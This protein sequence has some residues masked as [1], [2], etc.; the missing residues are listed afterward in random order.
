MKRRGAARLAVLLLL[1][2][3][4]AGGSSAAQEEALPGSAPLRVPFDR[5]RL[6]NGLTVI[7]HEDHRL[8]TVVVNLWFRVGSKDESPGRTG[9]AHLFEHLMFM[10]TRN[11]PNGQYDA[12]MEAA[13]GTNN[14][15]TSE[16]RT[17][18]VET[19][20]SNL[21]ETFLWL[22]ADRLANLADGMT[23]EKV[24]LQREVVKNERRESYENRPY[25]KAD[26][27]ISEQM[28]PENHPYHHPVIGSH[29]DLSA[30]TAED[31]KAFFRTYYVPSNASLVVAGDFAPARAR[32]M[33]ERTI[34][35]IPR[36]PEPSH[37]SPAPA[38]LQAEKRLILPDAVKLE[39]VMLAWHS[40]E[41]FGPGDAEC[42]VLASFL[43]GRKTSRLYRSLVYER[44]LAQN[45]SA[46]QRGSRYGG[47]FVVTATAQPGHGGAELERA[48]DEEIRGLRTSPPAPRDVEAA[49]ASLERQ[50]L[51]EMESLSE[52]ADLLNEFEFRFGDP[53]QLAARSL[54]R[55]R[56]VTASDLSR[57]AAEVLERP[58]LTIHVVGGKAPED[59]PGPAAGG[60]E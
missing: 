56:Q 29:A 22:E 33:V 41:S 5:Y 37:S 12:L 31:V 60:K 10:G 8:P 39:R 45:V 14:A 7:L 13:G 47:L 36:S 25:G 42:E 16:D 44:K 21:L 11:V 24:D 58:R 15:S 30:A 27:A 49:R 3:P 26:L 54:E 23:T 4:W 1:A 57:Q 34:G 53:G 32:E 40:P 9:F 55:F 51:E 19:G 35:R 43:G 6:S 20:P 18:Y 2:G 48:I 50:F 52:R 38:S 46:E 17:N 28:Y 59:R